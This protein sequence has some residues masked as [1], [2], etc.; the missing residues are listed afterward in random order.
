MRILLISV[1]IVGTAVLS[2]GLAR[3]EIVSQ[4]EELITEPI[5]EKAGWKK[6]RDPPTVTPVPEVTNNLPSI[7]KYSLFSEA[8]SAAGRRS[9]TGHKLKAESAFRDEDLMTEPLW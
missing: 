5:W 7:K 4:E 1:V 3:A 8:G 2:A 6:D 9:P